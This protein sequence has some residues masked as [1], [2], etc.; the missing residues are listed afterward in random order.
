MFCTSNGTHHAYHI[1]TEQYDGVTTKARRPHQVFQNLKKQATQGVEQ[2]QV[3]K[4]NFFLNVS[5]SLTE[6][7]FHC[8]YNFNV[9]QAVETEVL[10]KTT[11]QFQL[12]RVNFIVEVKHKQ[13]PLFDHVFTVRNMR[14][15]TLIGLKMST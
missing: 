12:C 11:C 4:S 3:Q 9:I 8:N 6:F 1:C 15:Q 2:G 10:R 14:I 5:E 7:V 13:N